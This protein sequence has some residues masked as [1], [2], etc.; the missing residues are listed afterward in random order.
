[1]LKR[2]LV[3]TLIVVMALSIML[4]LHDQQ[5]TRERLRDAESYIAY[6]GLNLTNETYTYNPDSFVSVQTETGHG[7]G[8]VVGKDLILTATHVIMDAKV[9][10]V[11]IHQVLYGVEFAYVDP[12]G[13][14]T[15][16]RVIGYTF[17]DDVI[18]DVYSGDIDRGEAVEVQGYPLDMAKTQ[19]FG[20]VCTPRYFMQLG[21][22]SYLDLYVCDLT[23]APGNSGSAML[24]NGMVGGL[25]VAINVPY[26]YTYVVASRSFVYIIRELNGE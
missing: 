16:L 5:E 11:E 15:V 7:S 22:C 4:I 17:P 23:C 26:D 10:K 12:I 14:V 18:L 13:D 25:V 19:T 3:G 2:I 1:M 24:Y 21:K 20:Y 8:T 6:I 9:V